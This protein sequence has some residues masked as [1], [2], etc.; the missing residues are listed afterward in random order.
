M[1][2][3]A[4]AEFKPVEQSVGLIAKKIEEQ[5]VA[6]MKLATDIA[7]TSSLYEDILVKRKELGKAKSKLDSAQKAVEKAKP[8]E[9]VCIFVV[10]MTC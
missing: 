9:K 10:V 6:R 8:D 7:R 1:H 2:A 5:N 3:F 4:G